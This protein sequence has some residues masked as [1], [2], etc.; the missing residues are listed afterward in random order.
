MGAERESAVEA[1][2]EKEAAIIEAARETFL[3][4]GFDAASMDAIA[5]NAGV[6]KR[7]VYNRF[8]SKEELFAA[9]IT[10][11]CRRILPLDIVLELDQG[12]AGGVV[13]EAVDAL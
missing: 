8:R 6:S 7:T 12:Y 13:G 11:T 10:E 3:A 4:R 1:V 9:A 2:D 5:L